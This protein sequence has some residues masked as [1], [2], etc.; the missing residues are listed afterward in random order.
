MSQKYKSKGKESLKNIADRLNA[1]N[2]NATLEKAFENHEEEK[3]SK[4]YQNIFENES[5]E[6]SNSQPTYMRQ[7]SKRSSDIYSNKSKL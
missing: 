1:I 6:Y 2:K 3:T 5:W 7:F 4:R